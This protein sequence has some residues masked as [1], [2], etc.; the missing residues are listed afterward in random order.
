MTGIISIIIFRVSEWNIYVKP[1]S[2]IVQ[3]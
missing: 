3:H 1:A 2:R